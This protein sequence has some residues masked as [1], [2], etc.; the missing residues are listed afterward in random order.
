MRAVAEGALGWGQGTAEQIRERISHLPGVKPQL[1]HDG[2]TFGLEVTRS[3]SSF[4][5]EIRRPIQLLSESARRGHPVCLV[6]DEFQQIGEI[7]KDLAGQFKA[8]TDDLPQVALVFAGSRRHL[9]ERLCIGAGAPLQN[10]ADPMSLD[11]IPEAKMIA[12]LRERAQSGGRGMTGE[13]AHEIYRLV[14]GIPH[15]VQLLAAAAWDREAIPIDVP[16]VKHGLVDVLVMQR[17]NLADR[18]EALTNTQKKLLQGLAG[19][20]KRQVDSKAFLDRADLAKSSA[21]RAREQLEGTEHIIWDDRMGWRLQDPIFERYL[22]HGRPLEM[23][24]GSDPETIA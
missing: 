14:R 20:Q 13:A 3:E 8:M 4:V 17:G 5:E 1:E 21:Q 9:M 6:L 19:S 11:V 22:I 18:F 10:V 7:D 15:F 2:W 24:E 16:V 23:G 12:F